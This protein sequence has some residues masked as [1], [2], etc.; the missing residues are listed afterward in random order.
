MKTRTLRLRGFAALGVRDF[1]FGLAVFWGIAL[2][3]CSTHEPAHAF[4]PLKVVAS[5]ADTISRTHARTY[6][7]AAERPSQSISA[8]SMPI[9]GLA[10][11]LLTMLNLAFAR[12]LHRTYAKPKA[13]RGGCDTQR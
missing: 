12:H 10:F 7:A 3:V 2:A 6:A 9:L 11:A 4:N 13:A 5:T 1:L 8:T